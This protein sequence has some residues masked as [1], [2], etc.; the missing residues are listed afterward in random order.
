MGTHVT[1]RQLRA[2]CAVVETGSFT[3]AAKSMHLSQAA[4]SGL[5]K[6]LES[7]VDVRLLDRSTRA[8]APSVVGEAFVPLVRRVIDDLDEALASLDNIKELRRGVVRVA[9]PETLSCTLLPEL[10]T[11]YNASHPDVDVRFDDVAIEEVVGGLQSGRIDIGFGPATSTDA[12]DIVTHVLWT[13]PL[14]VALHPHDPLAERDVVGWK[15]LRERTLFTYMRAFETRVLSNVPPRQQ[16]TRIVPVNRVNTALSML[17]VKPGAVVCPSMTRPLV[18]GFGL[19]I[20]PLKHP[21]VKRSI[22][23]YV[24]RRPSLSPA[25]ESFLGFSRQFARRWASAGSSEATGS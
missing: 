12:D 25:V 17:K 16:P 22:A 11:R 20:R 1:L 24:R 2:F 15:D 23:V 3:D 14:W 6:E 9:A 21:V 7:Q 10:I 18:T 8:V 19:V 4:L 13:D 5:V